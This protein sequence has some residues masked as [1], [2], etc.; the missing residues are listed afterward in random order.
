MKFVVSYSGGKESAL[1]LYKV[2]QAGYEPIALITT[3]NTDVG[4][5]FFHGLSED[6]LED[7]SRSLGV[8]IWLIKTSGEEYSVNFEKALLNA[9]AEGAEACIFGD[10]DIEGHKQ[11]CSER[12]KNVG[13]AS[14]FPL[15]G[16]RRDE[17]VFD[18]IDSGFTA[19]ITIVDTKFLGEEFLGQRLTRELAGRIAESGADICGEN[20]EYHTFVSNAPN[21]AHPIQFSFGKTARSGDYAMLPVMGG[22]QNGK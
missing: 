15:W 1:S 17:V 22:K 11:W 18:I 12:C 7:V 14:I 8:P 10:I 5:S 2:M 13:I 4:R 6:L 21:F 19:N 20:G 3:F 9:K 16:K